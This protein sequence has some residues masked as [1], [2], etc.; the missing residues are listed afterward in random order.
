MSKPALPGPHEGRFKDQI[1]I[2]TG[3]AS[4]I[5]EATCRRLV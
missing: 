3:G 1:A 5:G 2:V 4:G